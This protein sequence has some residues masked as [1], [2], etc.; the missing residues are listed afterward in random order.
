MTRLS[1][2]L[3]GS[4]VVAAPGKI[5][6]VGEYS[7]LEGGS[8]VVAAVSRYAVAQYLPELAPESRLIDETVKRATLA[9]GELAAALPRGSA[10]VNTAE[11][12]HRASKLGLGSSAAAAVAATGAVFATAGL[13]IKRHRELLFSV[14]DDGHRAAQGGVG[15]GA[16]IAAAVHGGF[17]GFVRPPGGKPISMRL[18]A[19][20]ALQIVVFWTG[21]PQ[22]TTSMIEGMQ[23]FAVRSRQ[24]YDWYMGKLRQIGERF[25]QAFSSND[26][27]GAIT[28]ADAYGRMLEKLGDSATLPIV[29][30]A[31]AQT[32]DLARSLGGTAKP[33]G[34]GGGDVGVAFFGEE[35]AAAEFTRRCP[36]GVS[37]LDVKV[38]LDGARRRLPGMV[39]LV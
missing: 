12:R 30:P 10:L 34:A 1:K 4:P 17:V 24:S 15:S 19:P 36:T 31:F 21:F 11:F 28:E 35:S 38:D 39:E 27:P 5:F 2:T 32:A 8:A 23:A 33:S 9:L 20:R 3:R 25:L 16:D 18:T 14:A 26:L 37:V 7:V 22:A 13:D 29:T 6:L